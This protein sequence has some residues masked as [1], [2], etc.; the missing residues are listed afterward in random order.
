MHYKGF[1]NKYREWLTAELML[2]WTPENCKF[3][4]DEK[5]AA[6]KRAQEEKDAA[7]QKGNSKGTAKKRRADSAVKGVR[8][9]IQS[10]LEKRLKT[11]NENIESKQLLALPSPTPVKLILEQY[12]RSKLKSSAPHRIHAANLV[13]GLR[14][15][16]DTVLENRLLYDFERA[17]FKQAVGKRKP[18]EVYGAE[19]LL[20]LLV[21]MP[22]L[23]QVGDDAL[24][25]AETRTME[26][27]LQDFMKWLSTKTG[28]K[29][30]F[31]GEWAK[32]D[33]SYIKEASA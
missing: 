13:T 19:H 1:S 17:Q 9:T 14:E 3:A 11:E 18:S 33:E 29:A 4:K 26:N 2:K 31:F 21:S 23:L 30:G 25:A 10:G 32:A 28:K 7:L 27:K 16:F 24:D 20:R 6:E 22:E 5:L 12:L 15:Y 8:L